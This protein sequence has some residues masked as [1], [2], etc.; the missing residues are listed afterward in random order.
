MN[1]SA[2][3]L[4]GY[5]EA[6][7][8]LLLVAAGRGGSSGCCWLNEAATQP[9]VQARFWL[10]S[11]PAVQLSPG[12]RPTAAADKFPGTCQPACR[13]LFQYGQYRGPR[14]LAARSDTGVQGSCKSSRW[15]SL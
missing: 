6:A 3:P 13:E 9:T 4:R 7:S 5:E 11:L 1:S 12:C 14:R 8:R 15:S 10:L 2:L